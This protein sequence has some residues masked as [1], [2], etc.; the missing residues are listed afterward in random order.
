VGA[1]VFDNLESAAERLGEI[2]MGI[3]WAKK[4]KNI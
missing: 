1:Q 3:S 4:G 2:D